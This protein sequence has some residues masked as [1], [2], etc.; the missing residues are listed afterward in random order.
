[1]ELR[2]A[3]GKSLNV[4]QSLSVPLASTNQRSHPDLAIGHDLKRFQTE[5]IRKNML[6]ILASIVIVECR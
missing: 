3:G 5:F 1:V 6:E 2:S 4:Q